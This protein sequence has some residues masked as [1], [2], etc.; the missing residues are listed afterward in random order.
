MAQVVVP[1][2]STYYSKVAWPTRREPVRPP[3]VG[4][5]PPLCSATPQLEF[6]LT[7][8]QVHISAPCRAPAT[9]AQLDIALLRSCSS[10]SSGDPPPRIHQCDSANLSRMEKERNRFPEVA[11][12][13][14]E[15]SLCPPSGML[16]CSPCSFFFA[17][18]CLSVLLALFC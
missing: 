11:T 12:L 1:S 18:L 3:R 6:T 13:D 10:D 9:Q 17:A 7:L 14:A 15:A 8:S 5:L 4:Q 16:A 2:I